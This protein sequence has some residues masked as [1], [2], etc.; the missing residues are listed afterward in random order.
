M[1]LIECFSVLV[2]SGNGQRCNKLREVVREHLLTEDEV[3][4]EIKVRIFKF[5]RTS[6][7]DLHSKIASELARK[8][9]VIYTDING[10][11]FRHNMDKRS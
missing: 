9:S 2:A 11:Y 4:G 7:P 8:V 5:G 3:T 6:H 10:S 1:T